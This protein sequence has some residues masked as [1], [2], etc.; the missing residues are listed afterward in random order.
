[1]NVFRHVD[2][3]FIAHHIISVA[4]PETGITGALQHLVLFVRERHRG[5]Q[6]NEWHFLDVAKGKYSETCVC[7]TMKATDRLKSILCFAS[8]KMTMETSVT[9]GPETCHLRTTV[10][11]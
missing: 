9:F 4:S 8:F 10:A 11:L 7:L 2:T 5:K 6:N 1:M 3:L